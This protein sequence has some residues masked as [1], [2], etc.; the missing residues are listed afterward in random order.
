MGKR[1]VAVGLMLLS[2]VLPANL[3]AAST[4]EPGWVCL[5]RCAIL[6]VGYTAENGVEAGAHYAA[7]CAAGCAAHAYIY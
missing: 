6:A 5:A 4:E 2:A 1:R 3:R 7:G